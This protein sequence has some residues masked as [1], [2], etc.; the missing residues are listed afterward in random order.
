MPLVERALSP[1]GLYIH[2]VFGVSLEQA[3]KE[4]LIFTA[5]F[6]ALIEEG[7]RRPEYVIDEK[8]L[9]WA[10]DRWLRGLEPVL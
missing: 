8:E 5:I 6:G 9:A 10:V 7:L 1:L 3:R 4:V 2:T